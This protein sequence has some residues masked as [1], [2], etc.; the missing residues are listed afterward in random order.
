MVIRRSAQ[1]VNLVSASTHFALFAAG[2]LDL[3]GAVK[4]L[5]AELSRQELTRLVTQENDA[6]EMS[7]TTDPLPLGMSI[8]GM[9]PKVGLIEQGGATWRASVMA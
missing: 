8:S 9:R 7:V 4:A 5:P 1:L 2:G 3:L 6:L